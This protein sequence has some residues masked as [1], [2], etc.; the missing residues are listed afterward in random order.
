MFPRALV[1]K[2]STQAILLLTL[3]QNAGN[4][5]NPATPAANFAIL[6]GATKRG[7]QQ[8]SDLSKRGRYKNVSVVVSSNIGLSSIVIP[9]PVS[10]TQH[11][12]SIRISLS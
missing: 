8:L 2:P 10:G 1:R 3:P 6:V 4:T 11:S 12:E 9:V 7:M 5:L